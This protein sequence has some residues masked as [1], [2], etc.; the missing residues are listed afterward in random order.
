MSE[1]KVSKRLKWSQIEHFP[2]NPILDGRISRM[3]ARWGKFS[4]AS[5]GTPEVFLNDAEAFPEFPPDTYLMGDGNHRKAWAERESK[6][7][8]TVICT[9][10]RGLTNKRMHEEFRRL[11]D[12]RTIAA[13]E[14]FIH[15]VQA[16]SRYHVT[17]NEIV[18]STGFRVALSQNDGVLR[19]VSVF[20]WI[21][22]DVK[23]I[24]AIR[25]R[26]VENGNT[27][28]RT[29][30]VRTLESARLLYGTKPGGNQASLLRGLGAFW[31]RYGED[32]QM[33]RLVENVY[34]QYP[35]PKRLVTAGEDH[36]DALCEPSWKGIALVV[37]N[38][39]NG[40]R[41]SKADLPEWMS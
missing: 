10:W 33:A 28:H 7:D 12:R 41:R 27:P 34:A 37:R 16:G 8:E 36:A 26:G 23:D 17:I 21:Y 9:I 5:A 25:N 20:D 14:D 32:P 30:L 15:A 18:E 35:N 13:Y 24:A 38:H 40:R 11:N 19:C 22:N 3:K 4:T 2:E 29:E 1:S 31:L 39:Y 6:G